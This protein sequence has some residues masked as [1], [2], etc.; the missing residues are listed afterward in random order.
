MIPKR[1]V[2]LVAV[3]IWLAAVVQGRA[4]HA[5]SI[6]GAQPDLRL[7]TLAC[8]A[9]LLGPRGALLGFWT[10]LL[11]ASASPPLM[12]G[13]ASLYYGGLF[14]GRL[15]AGTLAGG[16]GRSLTSG[17]FL[18]PP[19]VTLAATLLAEAVTVVVA[20]GLALHHLRHWAWLAGTGALYNM[21]L[22]LPVSLL[23]RGLGV[24][25]L[26]ENPFGRL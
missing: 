22:A 16:L 5:L 15:L 9:L 3:L 10:G 13:A 25:R 18:V 2:I 23:L 17:N 24:G 6:H 4:A 21:M 26:R 7:V 14:L 12:E 20:P 19:L 8:G 1:Q 11:T